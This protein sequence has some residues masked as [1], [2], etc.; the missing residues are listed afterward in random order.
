MRLAI[1]G[2]LLFVVPFAVH[3]VVWRIR[4]PRRRAVFLLLLFLGP[5]PVAA[6]LPH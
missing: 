4:R 6:A 5:L 2:I 3:V 1:L